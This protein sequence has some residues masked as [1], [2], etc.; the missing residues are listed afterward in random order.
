MAAG[1]GRGN[2]RRCGR[3][4]RSPFD[5]GGGMAGGGSAHAGAVPITYAH[6]GGIG[7]AQHVARHHLAGDEQVAAGLAY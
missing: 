1:S 5:E 4:G 3:P 2:S 7:L 6:T